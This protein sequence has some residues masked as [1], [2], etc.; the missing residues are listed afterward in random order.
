MGVTTL[1]TSNAPDAAVLD[2]CGAD[3][4]AMAVV[5]GRTR[6]KQK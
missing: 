6:K 5:N 4:N 2:R 1:V 3:Q